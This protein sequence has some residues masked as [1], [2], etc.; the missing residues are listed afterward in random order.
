MHLLFGLLMACASPKKTDVIAG[1]IEEVE[2][3]ED[4]SPQEGEIIDL[5]DIGI[6][7]DPF[8][9]CQVGEYACNFKFLNQEGDVI[10]LHDYLGKVI[11]LDFSTVWCHW[12]KVAAMEEN[13]ILSQ[14]SSDEVVWITVL[15]EDKTGNT[16]S[17]DE[18]LEWAEEYNL[19]SPVLV[20]DPTKIVGDGET[21]YPV[22]GF[23]C[24][25]II[26]KEMT[27]KML[28]PGWNGTILTN[29]IQENL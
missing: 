23:P 7:E 10:E 5:T 21:G 18:A 12:C 9:G 14:F 6:I 16:V 20:G 25:F 2:I 22:S 13:N 11:V 29:A 27:I 1:A 3:V 17:V 4:T 24:F 26:N 28:L 19:H 8:C 15:L